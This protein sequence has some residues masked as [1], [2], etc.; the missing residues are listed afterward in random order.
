MPGVGLPRKAVKGDTGF[1]FTT[2][3]GTREAIALGWE[4]IRDLQQGTITRTITD[5]THPDGPTAHQIVYYAPFDNPQ[6]ERDY[7]A[8]CP[9]T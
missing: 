4:D 3:E 8:R 1:T 5:D 7:E 6:R 9:A 2:P